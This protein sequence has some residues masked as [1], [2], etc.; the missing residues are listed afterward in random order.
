[1]IT[2]KS[3]QNTK[4]TRLVFLCDL[5]VLCGKRLNCC[6][7]QRNQTQLLARSLRRG[8]SLIE[9]MVAMLVALIGVFGVFALI[10]FAV[11]QVQIGMNEDA[12]QT[13]GRNGMADFEAQGFMNPQRWAAPDVNG[14]RPAS[15]LLGDC[16]WLRPNAD[17][18]IPMTQFSPFAPAP[19]NFVRINEL[20]PND[21]TFT[22]SPP[23][24]PATLGLEV[25]DPD[26]NLLPPETATIYYRVAKIADNP[27]GSPSLNG[28]GE[29]LSVTC[30]LI[31]GINVIA[32]GGPHILTGQW[33][34]YSFRVPFS[35]VA[36]WANVQ[37]QFN[38]PGPAIPIPGSERGCGISWAIVGFNSVYCIDPWGWTHHGLLPGV[39]DPSLD[40]TVKQSFGVVPFTDVPAAWPTFARLSLFDNTDHNLATIFPD[41]WVFSKA[42]ARRVFSGHDDMV[43]DA[44]LDDFS[45]PTQQLFAPDGGR[46][47]SGRLSWQMF[48][49]RDSRNFGHSRFYAVASLAR[50]PD[51]KD[52]L[53]SVGSPGPYSGGGDL[54]LNEITVP[55]AQIAIR[56]GQWIMLI[57]GTFLPNEKVNDIAFYR[58]LEADETG[59]THTVTLQGSDLTPEFGSSVYAVLLP[60]VIAVYERTLRFE[61]SSSWK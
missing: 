11:R 17:V 18:A 37:L 13:L 50:N 48:V 30:S 43:T 32:T 51:S 61:T 4:T 10:A 15:Y 47:Y 53:F 58:V 33:L 9:V 59:G 45:G 29:D 6:S 16:P 35:A 57:D 19:A 5:C 25:S 27:P 60:D 24:Q 44:P 31:E 23:G 49:V 2:T 38:T 26:P 28:T 41:F 12:A 46:Q 21:T 36:D 3:T 55:P 20:L 7:G 40:P 52:R 54:I 1:M 14:I 39:L 22:Y 42:L 34:E 56:R 8:I